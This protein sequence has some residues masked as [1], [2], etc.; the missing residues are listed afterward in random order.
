MGSSVVS[1]EN[2]RNPFVERRERASGYL[3]AVPLEGEAERISGLLDD[4]FKKRP[5]SEK[6]TGRIAN[7]HDVVRRIRNRRCLT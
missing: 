3:A 5:V 1:Y 6:T 7:H 2:S 4:H